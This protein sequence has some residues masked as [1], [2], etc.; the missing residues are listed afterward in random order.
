MPYLLGLLLAIAAAA[1][2]AWPL[3]RAPR[4]G[5]PPTNPGSLG[6]LREV[7]RQ[8]RQL[9]DEI[10]T[11]ALDIE[12]GNVPAEE[13]AEAIEA[14]RLRAALFLRQEDQ[15]TSELVRMMQE[16]EDEVLA[17]RLANGSVLRT[18]ACSRCGGARD[19]DAEFCPGC[20][21]DGSGLFPVDEEAT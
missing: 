2:I 1:L 5:P 18:T 13:Y 12:L 3:L 17:L 7:Q 14:H 10:R 8:R 4:A 11:L 9:Y 21:M 19:A 16:I 15:L 20:E 6:L